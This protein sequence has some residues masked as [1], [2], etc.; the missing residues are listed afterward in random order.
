MITR[1]LPHSLCNMAGFL[2]STVVCW[3]KFCNT[4]D[5]VAWPVDQR[6]IDSVTNATIMCSDLD[7]DDACPEREGFDWSGAE[8]YKNDKGGIFAVNQKAFFAVNRKANDIVCWGSK[9]YGG[10]CPEKKGFDWSD[11]KIYNGDQA[12]FAVNRKANDIVCWGSTTTAV[13]SSP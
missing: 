4:P 7:G 10:R 5:S 12:F 3:G 8:I 13:L 1:N 6:F 2:L 11:A 9:V